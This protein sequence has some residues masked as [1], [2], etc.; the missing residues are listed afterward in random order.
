M[1][2]CSHCGQ[3]LPKCY[4]CL[5]YMG[6]SNPQLE[7]IHWRNLQA[8]THAHHQD[9]SEEKKPTDASS[10]NW[11]QGSKKLA[12]ELDDVTQ[13]KKG[14]LSVGHWFMWCQHCKHGGHALCIDQWFEDRKLCGVNGCNCRCL[15]TK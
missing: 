5:M 1:S 7:L 14:F 13:Q 9:F 2:C 11:T 15:A 8:Q 3:P 12:D 6:L 10:E 4:V